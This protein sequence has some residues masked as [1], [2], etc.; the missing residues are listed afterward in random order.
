MKLGI[1]GGTFDPVHIAHLILAER[2]RDELQLDEVWFVPAPSPPHKDDRGITPADQRAEMLQL[3]IAG[4]P[5]L[6]VSRIEFDR[7]GPS[8]TVDTLRQLVDEGADR[9]LFLLVGADSLR[10]LG[11]WRE[12]ERIAELATIVAVNRGRDA[13][14][15]AA[16]LQHWLGDKIAARVRQVSI[17]AIDLSATEIRSRVAQERTVR[18]HIPRAVEAYIHEH[19]LYCP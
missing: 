2:C 17:P 1:F 9:E 4:C 11:S 15:E 19:R 12:P 7:A 13:L 16:E 5:H 10:D 14:P 6:A 18:F 3:A 8:Y